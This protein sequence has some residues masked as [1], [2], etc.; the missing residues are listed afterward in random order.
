MKVAILLSSYNGEKFIEK[1]IESL[2]N[3][4]YDN[5]EI[6][7]RDDGSTDG[8]I[9]IINTYKSFDKVTI[10]DDNAN[11][12]P[13]LSFFYILS[14]VE[15]DIYMF[16]DQD[17]IWE[18]NKLSVFT[19]KFLNNDDVA[20]LVHSDLNLIDENDMNLNDTFNLRQGINIKKSYDIN[21]I[22][23]QNCFVGCSLGFNHKLRELSL[24]DSVNIKSKNV[25]MHDWWFGIN[26]ILFGKVVFIPELVVNY[27]QHDNNVVG[28]RKKIHIKDLFDYSYYIYKYRSFNNYL[29]RICDQQKFIFLLNEGRL[30]KEVLDVLYSYE[31]ILNPS[32]KNAW[33]LFKNRVTFGSIKMNCFFIINYLL[34][35]MFDKFKK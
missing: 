19:S 35:I 24:F 20:L 32:F 1:Q 31:Y 8:T 18:P 4:D 10:I 22:I 34:N 17:D 12:G 6:F 30:N 33:L 16:C 14:K 21:Q 25:F 7:I 23:V 15:S 26:A 29:N 9:E 13:S 3:Q 5:F 27:R 2:L 28:T 11:L